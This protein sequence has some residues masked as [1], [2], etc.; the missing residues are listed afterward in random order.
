MTSQP[1]SQRLT[2][3]RSE[4]DKSTRATRL[5]AIA[6]RGAL[7]RRA[8]RR[9]R[10]LRWT[11]ITMIVVAVALAITLAVL[12]FQT[13]AARDTVR[14]DAQALNAASSA[15]TTMLTA[16]PKYARRYADSVIALSTGGQRDRLAAGRDELVAEIAGQQVASTGVVLSAGLITDPSDASDATADVLIVAE[17]TNPA[18]IGG[19]PAQK[20]MPIIVTMRLVDGSWKVEK[21]GLQ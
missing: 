16:D 21:A 5:A 4:L 9:R 6:A 20:R 10:I 1:A 15:V 7:A 11:T 17:A 14:R 8:H 12:P 2:T 18:L 3:A 13:T 19:D